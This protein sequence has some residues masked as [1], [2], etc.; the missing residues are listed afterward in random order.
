VPDAGELRCCGSAAASRDLFKRFAA[1]AGHDFDTAQPRLDVH[2]PDGSRLH[3]VMPPIAA[4]YT[5]RHR[6]PLQPFQP[7]TVATANCCGPACSMRVY[8]LVEQ[9]GLAYAWEPAA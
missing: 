6:P 3:A 5:A 8:D 7:S 9:A 4:E 2:L 1:L